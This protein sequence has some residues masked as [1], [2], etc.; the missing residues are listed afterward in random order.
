MAKSNVAAEV[1][2]R[3]HMIKAAGALAVGIFAPAVLRVRTARAAYP[4]RPIKI[5]VANSPGGPSDITA[6]ILAAALQQAIGGS[7]CGEQGRRRRQHRH[8]LRRAR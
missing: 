8:G 2:S 6:R 1:L 5:V 7:F 3:R 4:D